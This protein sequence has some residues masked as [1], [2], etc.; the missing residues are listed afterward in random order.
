MNSMLPAGQPL[1]T[2]Y[3]K[4][5][6]TCPS[7]CDPPLILKAVPPK[8]S[9]QNAICRCVRCLSYWEVTP[10]GKVVNQRRAIDLKLEGIEK[11]LEKIQKMEDEL[12]STKLKST[13]LGDT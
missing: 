4:A 7:D 12:K 9:F 13:K 1:P 3:E 2:P 11:M 10:E 8:L 5:I 6:N